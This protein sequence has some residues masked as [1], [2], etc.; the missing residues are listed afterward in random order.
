MGKYIKKYK[1]EEDMLLKDGIATPHVALADDTGDVAYLPSSGTFVYDENRKVVGDSANGESVIYLLFDIPSAGTYNILGNYPSAQFAGLQ[2]IKEMSVNGQSIPVAKNW[3]F[4]SAGKYTIKIVVD[5]GID[6]LFSL[7]NNNGG[8][9]YL[10]GANIASLKSSSASSGA[11][12]FNLCKN[13]K[14]VFGAENLDTSNMTSLLTTFQQCNNLERIDLTNWNVSNVTELTSILYNC[15]NLEYIGN[16]SNWDVSSCG[17]FRQVFAHCEKLKYVG[18]LSNWDTHSAT[19]FENTFLG[20]YELENVGDLSNWQVGNV[21][22]MLQMFSNCK[23]LKSVGDLS[24]WDVSNVETMQAMFYECNELSCI[25]DLSNWDVGKVTTMQSMFCNCHKLKSVGDLSNWNVGDVTTMKQMF[26]NCIS[27][28]NIVGLNGWNTSKV[29]DMY[30][31]LGANEGRAM[32]LKELDLSN[33]NV[34]NV[35]RFS[36]LFLNCHK[37]KSVGD[38]SNWNVGNATEM[39]VMFNGCYAMTDAGDLSNW[40]TTSLT[41]CNHMF[42]GCKSLTSIGKKLNWDVS[43]VTDMN[44]MFAGSA[45]E[46]IDLSSWLP[47]EGCDMHALFDPAHNDDGSVFS[48]SKIRV[49]GVPSITATSN[50]NNMFKECYDLTTIT[51]SGKISNSVDFSWS[52]L[53]KASALVLFDALDGAVSGKTITLSAHTYGLLRSRDIDIATSKGWI[54]ES[55]KR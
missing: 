26:S 7:F 14:Y 55:V 25:G 3:A 50:T 34:G 23:E 28:E 9:T 11:R 5:K 24:K 12:M 48:F 47:K 46:E 27:M 1:S 42:W 32:L 21:T 19:K 31:M 51:A 2:Y 13:I 10:V 39:D 30:L 29:T 18:D 6:S 35:T 53:T 52:P 40:Q 20:C 41:I 16:L 54:V 43:K 15:Y 8:N 4:P 22:T 49:L 37:L 33:W 36:G 44:N 45:I 38:L 17:N